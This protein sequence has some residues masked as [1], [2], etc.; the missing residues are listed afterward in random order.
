MR[1]SFD[2]L[3]WKQ[4]AG[5]GLMFSVP[6]TGA[7]FAAEG[8]PEDWQLG[9]QP[10]ATPIA[11]QMHDFHDLLLVI[12]T[13]IVI[14]VLALLVW[15]M[16]RYNEK[17]NPE[18]SRTSHNTVIEVVWTVVPVLILLVIAVPSFRLL[19]AQFDIPK[20]DVTIKATGYQWYWSYSYPD[21]GGIAFD[22]ILVEKEDLK[23]DQ[24]YLLAVDNEVVV[25][26]NKVVHVLVTSADVM[27]NW[28]MPAFG[29]KMDAIQGRT[30]LTWF[31][32]TKP[33]V[34]YGQCS[35]LCGSR[36]AYMPIA[37]RAVSDEEFAAWVDQKNPKTA[38]TR[39]EPVKASE[40]QVEDKNKLALAQPR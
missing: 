12:I 29:S 35:E 38:S 21:H 17:A 24:S 33:G 23:P 26:V 36:H 5:L 31:K 20:A 13:A 8:K 10:A 2:G 40:N 25:P 15:V 18:P 39:Q 28:A 37:V 1:L 19:Y 34:Y 7:A 22:S 30:N 3:G 9:F 4:I 14:F 32:V 27:H 16:V 6:G 11:Q